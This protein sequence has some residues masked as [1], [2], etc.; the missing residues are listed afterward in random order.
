MKKTTKHINNWS[1]G[2]PCSC[3]PPQF[4]PLH[5]ISSGAG[6]HHEVWA[7]ARAGP[8]LPRARHQPLPKVVTHLGV[9]WLFELCMLP[10]LDLGASNVRMC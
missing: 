4:L 5:C 3:V 8:G 10:G 2:D 7:L 1:T 6:S 9:N